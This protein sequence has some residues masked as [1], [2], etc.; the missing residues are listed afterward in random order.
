MRSGRIALREELPFLEHH[1]K[2]APAGSHFVKS[3]Q[4]LARRLGNQNLARKFG[5][6]HVTDVD[7][8]FM[9]ALST[10]PARMM[11]SWTH[12]PPSQL[13]P[14]PPPSQPPSPS[15]SQQWLSSVAAELSLELARVDDLL[16]ALATRQLDTETLRPIR[17][18][19]DDE[20][21]LH[22]FGHWLCAGLDPADPEP[23]SDDPGSWRGAPTHRRAYQ[24]W[25]AREQRRKKR[26]SPAAV[27][28]PAPTAP[29]RQSAASTAAASAAT[30]SAAATPPPPIATVTVSRDGAGSASIATTVT[31]TV[32][33]APPSA[34]AQGKQLLTAPPTDAP[35]AD[36]LPD[37]LPVS[38]TVAA[39]L[40]AI[41]AEPTISCAAPF[42]RPTG[43]TP[44][45]IGGPDDGK[46]CNWDGAVPPRGCWRNPDGSRHAVV[47]NAQRTV[48]RAAARAERAAIKE[49]RIE[50]SDEESV[51]RTLHRVIERV[52]ST[53]GESTRQMTRKRR[54]AILRAENEAERILKATHH[55]NQ[56]VFN[57]K[58]YLVECQREQSI[59]APLQ[60]CSCTV[61]HN[62]VEH[63]LSWTYRSD[64]EAMAIAL[65]LIEQLGLYPSALSG[66]F[67]LQVEAVM[68]IPIKYLVDRAA[69]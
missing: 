35:P 31:T 32:S 11:T 40:L 37:Q 39:D 42:R 49:E 56:D 64:H 68:N 47:Q 3:W 58:R 67:L 21:P 2:C 33:P 10:A 54:A 44:R 13:P 55:S 69:A 26:P 59:A 57:R 36:P 17:I 50:M 9:N 52:A 22:E 62:G 34:K 60:H 23:R 43:P 27:F 24:S 12:N 65:E 4:Q 16:A 18:C 14:S 38:A 29:R 46:E 41:N 53:N 30:A 66:E 28:A 61:E 6:V 5:G 15:T 20:E 1:A 63:H 25:H 19:A 45:V 51:R 8:F 48:D 7:N